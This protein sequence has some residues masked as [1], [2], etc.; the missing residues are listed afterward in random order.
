MISGAVLSRTHRIE[1]MSDFMRGETVS[2]LA[3]LRDIDGTIEA[4]I[5]VRR[6]MDALAEAAE[7]LCGRV[8][9]ELL[10]GKALELDVVPSL[11]QSQDALHGMVE[12]MEYKLEAARCAPELN[13]DDG[14]VDAYE[15]AINAV[16]I[17]NSKVEKL[18]WA[19][20]ERG[21][22]SEGY[23]QAKVLRT[24]TDIDDFLDSL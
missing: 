10:E 15:Q 14:V 5:L 2:S 9:T 11:E 22:D 17:L 7:Q 13:A 21:A 16:L 20:L 12:V 19:V 1:R 4:L 18:R 23:H 3:L 8:N 6:N 24:D